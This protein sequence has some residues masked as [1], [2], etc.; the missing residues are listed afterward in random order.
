MINILDLLAVIDQANEANVIARKCETT[1]AQ[2]MWRICSVVD[3][4]HFAMEGIWE[5]TGTIN[6]LLGQ[7]IAKYKS[8]ITM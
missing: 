7:S 6:V 5:D 1:Y 3:G 8:C 4:S 2:L